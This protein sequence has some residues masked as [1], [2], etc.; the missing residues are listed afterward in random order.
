MKKYGRSYFLAAVVF[1]IGAG[2]V[3]P[4]PKEGSS[5]MAQQRSELKVTGFQLV[6]SSF[7]NG[8]PLPSRCAYTGGNFSPNLRWGNP[9]EGTQSLALIADD[10]DA[11]AGDWVHW[12]LI[13]IPVNLRELKEGISGE[14]L[15]RMGIVEGT[16][17][18]RAPGYGGPC[19]PSG[20][21]RYFFKLYALD[22]ILPLSEKTTKKDLLKAM[23]DHI[24]SE[25]QLWGIYQKK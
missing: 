23:K 18:F 5:T 7:E 13:N 17:D 21:H 22:T 9:P 1:L 8:K 3:L 15:K 25:S 19:P 12:V 10:P 2:P 24:L 14:E 20:T 16:T 4:Q 6:S 11:P